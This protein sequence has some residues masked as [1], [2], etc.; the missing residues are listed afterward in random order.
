MLITHGARFILTAFTFA[1]LAAGC[2]EPNSDDSG[3][4]N[5]GGDSGSGGTNGNNSGALCQNYCNRAEECPAVTRLPT[6]LDD[7][8]ETR[9]GAS[10]FGSAC[11][12]AV[13][14]GL[15]CLTSASCEDFGLSAST[16]RT[17]ECVYEAYQTRI[18]DI[19]DTLEDPIITACDATCAQAERCPQLVAEEG[20]RR[21]CI[22]NF[23]AYD[24]TSE[25]CESAALVGF[26]C[27]A[28]LSCENL[29]NL[30][31]DRPHGCESQDQGI[32]VAC[33]EFLSSSVAALVSN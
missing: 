27:V 14:E 24:G 6:C 23:N 11:P 15:A 9:S 31:N 8:A 4:G 26:E 13:D 33:E 18:C 21:T 28:G 22:E 10:D 30:I 20:C 7:C 17:E 25:A 12:E 3:G 1:A 2:A 16:G 5:S 32:V 29:D 19:V